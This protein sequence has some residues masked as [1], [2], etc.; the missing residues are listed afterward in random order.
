MYAYSYIIEFL[1]NASASY[2]SLV[3]VLGH[4]SNGQMSS[5]GMHRLG[6]L[7]NEGRGLLGGEAKAALNLGCRV[8]GPLSL[9]E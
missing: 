9:H 4:R 2:D 3:E 7:V 5:F 6:R 1:W 8:M